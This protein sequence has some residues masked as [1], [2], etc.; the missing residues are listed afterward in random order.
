MKLVDTAELTALVSA[1]ATAFIEY[2]DEVPDKVLGDFHK[3]SRDRF[4]RWMRMVSRAESLLLHKTD[5]EDLSAGASTD[6]ASLAE[7]VLISEMLTRIWVVTLTAWDRQRNQRRAEPI[8]RNVMLGHMLSRHQVLTVLFRTVGVKTSEMS[9]VDQIRNRVQRWSDLL[10]GHML[11]RYDL[12][13]FAFDSDRA[14]EFADDYKRR[15]I[16]NPNSPV[17]NLILVGLRI[18]FPPNQLASQFAAPHDRA[19][20]RSILQAFPE[21]SL[22]DSGTVE[23]SCGMIGPEV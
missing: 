23:V 3:H 19:V 7:Q 11:D 1:H 9:R 2:T 18:A 10:M 16:A 12:W 14:R 17:W 6:L 5:D 22:M 15:D 8:A 20:V 21:G 4:H 13:D